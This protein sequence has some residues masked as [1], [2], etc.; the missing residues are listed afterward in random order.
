[1]DSLHINNQI[2]LRSWILNVVGCPLG[3]RRV[4]VGL[5]AHT[6]R[7]TRVCVCVGMKIHL[8]KS[9]IESQVD[10]A[11]SWPLKKQNEGTDCDSA[12]MILW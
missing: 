12:T 3:A 7:H 1:M 10:R 8:A 4:P 11:K 6:H 2:F 5:C 9:S